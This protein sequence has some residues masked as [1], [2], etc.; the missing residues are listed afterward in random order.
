MEADVT[1]EVLNGLGVSR[2]QR[3]LD[4][5]KDIA[6]LK[7]NFDG[8]ASTSENAW[9]DVEIPMLSYAGVIFFVCPLQK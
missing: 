5:V 6:G 9:V 7:E 3:T 2:S 8:F 4:G 1:R